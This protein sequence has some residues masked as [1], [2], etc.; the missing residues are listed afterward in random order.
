M[1]ASLRQTIPVALATILIGG[2]V[3]ATKAEGPFAIAAKITGSHVAV[4]ITT[5]VPAKNL[6]LQLYGTDGLEVKD[7]VQSGP[8]KVK[9]SKRATLATGETWMV[10]ADFTQP[11][12][13][14]HLTVWV[15]SSGQP[16]VVRSF[17]VGEL[18]AK[19]KTERNQGVRLD[20]DGQPIRISE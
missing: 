17:A 2:A 11:E 16:S 3:L 14:S 6:E 13:L 12:G 15:G 20:P 5:P 19:Q 4:M 8:L 10:E 1:I 7:A 9:T 18:S